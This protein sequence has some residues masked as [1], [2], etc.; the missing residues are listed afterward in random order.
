MSSFRK[1]KTQIILIIISLVFVSV[2]N[3]LGDDLGYR[4]SEYKIGLALFKDRD[5]IGAAESWIKKGEMIL[6]GSKDASSFKRAALANVL[7]TTAFERANNARVYVT[8]SAAVRYFLEGQTNW[9][10]ESKKIGKISKEKVT[11]FL[12]TMLSMDLYN[13]E[14]PNREYNTKSGRMIDLRNH[15]SRKGSGWSAIDIGRLLIWLGIAKEWYPEIRRLVDK[16]VDRWKL[17]RVCLY[18][19]LHGA[20]F[21][22]N[23]EYLHQEGRL[24]YEQYSAAGYRLWGS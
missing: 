13:Q 6:R 16:A 2:P 5:F 19:E 1:R 9:E 21:D 4:F 11:V 17:D 14:L 12:E 10:K 3:S 23:K 20:L 15:L 24:G 22:G 7:A 18:Q 8:W